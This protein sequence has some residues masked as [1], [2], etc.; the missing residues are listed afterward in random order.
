MM[1][2]LLTRDSRDW[3]A[4][5]ALSKAHVASCNTINARYFTLVSQAHNQTEGGFL[6]EILP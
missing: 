3:Q 4:G 5:L 6:R 2:Y 1:S